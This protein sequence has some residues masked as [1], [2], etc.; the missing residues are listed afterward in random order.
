MNRSKLNSLSNKL[1]KAITLLALFYLVI[2]LLLMIPVGFAQ[3]D[4]NHK[5]LEHKLVLSLSGSA[6]I[7]LYVN[8]DEIAEEVI[9]ALL[10]HEEIDAVKLESD[11]GIAFASNHLVVEEEN[12]WEHANKYRLYSPTDGEPLG[13][14]Y[15]H[16]KH[17]ALQQKALDRVFN[18][19]LF[20]LVQFLVTVIALILVFNRTIG[21]PLT[22]LAD[23]LYS[24]TPED[25]KNIPIDNDNRNNELGVVV[26]SVNTFIENSRQAIKRERELRSQIEHW[27]HY[28]RNL[29]EQDILTGL[30]NRL[31]CE[32]YVNQA[33]K[34]CE[35]IA[36]LLV[37]L[38]GFKAVN[39]TYGHAAGDLILTELASRLSSLQAKSNVPGVV[40]RIGGDEFVVYLVLQQNDHELLTQVATHIIEL[41]NRPATYNGHTIKVGC[42]VGIAVQPSTGIEIERLLHRADRAMYRVKEEGKNNYQFFHGE[43]QARVEKMD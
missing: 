15:I 8:N 34:S 30:K 41:A 23:T 39:D 33:S 7:A 32:K 26:H 10:L 2:I 5:E 21:R 35:Y 36:L 3:A 37:D 25:P 38:D 1:L 12:L 40:G 16:N 19:V 11:E 20:I 18:Q 28:Y 13:A 27:E 42:S 24:T 9:S 14:I 17:A 22:A 29:A 31:G 43:R 6:A 4:K